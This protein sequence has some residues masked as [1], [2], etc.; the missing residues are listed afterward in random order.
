MNIRPFVQADILRKT[1][2][3]QWTKDRGKEPKRDQDAFL[4]FWKGDD[5]IGDRV[6]NIH[7]TTAEKHA[8]RRKKQ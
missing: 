7:L 2:N 8:R 6:N 4:W 5:F 1:P 3:I